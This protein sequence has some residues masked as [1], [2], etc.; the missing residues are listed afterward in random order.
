MLLIMHQIFK[1]K[2]NLQKCFKSFNFGSHYFL[3]E[4]NLIINN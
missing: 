4:I 1:M 2:L 3:L